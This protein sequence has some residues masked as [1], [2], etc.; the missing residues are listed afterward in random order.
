MADRPREPLHFA[1]IDAVRGF[2][3]LGVLSVHC[4]GVCGHF[5]FSSL[6]EQGGYGV[7]LFF[8][9]SAITLCYSMSTRREGEMHHVNFYVR[10]LFR[11]APLF[12]M[13][14]LLY[15]T[16]PGIIPRIW[17]TLWAPH[18][19][20]ASYFLLTA[21][22]L[23][24]WH[25]YAFNSVVPGGWSIAVEMTFYLVFPFCFHHISTLR[26][27]ALCVLCGVVFTIG[28]RFLFDHLKSRIWPDA[29]NPGATSFLSQYWFPSQ[30]VVFLVGIFVYHL[31]KHPDAPKI[32][33][34][35][36]WSSWLLVV[37][38]MFLIN[39]LHHNTGFVSPILI[40]IAL[41]GTI[42]SLA[43]NAVPRVVNPLICHLGKLSYSCYLT[44][45]A[46]L[47]LSIRLFRII[48]HPY[49]FKSELGTDT[50]DTG[51]SLLNLGVF[52]LVMLTTL[53]LTVLFSTVTYHLIENPGIK[54]G[55]M[56]IRHLN[57]R[58]ALAE[59]MKGAAT[60]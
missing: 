50:F 10:R 47:A 26:R 9:A 11:I 30:F 43:G 28:E 14:M 24:G 5:P 20:H 21:L 16:V 41:S 19:V 13:S 45:F 2:A 17:L 8:M 37:C 55:K 58:A 29:Q 34:S 15:W 46:A 6:A 3:F 54:L 60:V 32:N 12:W 42:F 23:Q 40:V 56:V 4:A 1:Y 31:L 22:F 36:F 51:S 59:K 53:V 52:T 49:A 38:L 35:P 39:L 27:A 25:P 18:G 33:K 7:Q 44:H 48:L 57:E